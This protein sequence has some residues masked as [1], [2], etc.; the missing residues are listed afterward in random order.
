KDV[1]L[2]TDSDLVLVA[3]NH[4]NV[5]K[6]EASK[7][8]SQARNSIGVQGMKLDGKYEVQSISSSKEGEFVLTIGEFGF[9]KLRS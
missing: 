9:G 8:R 1:I 3:N 4:K 2:V 5:V 6:F 7:I